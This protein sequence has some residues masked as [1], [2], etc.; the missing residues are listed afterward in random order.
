MT[1]YFKL[2]SEQERSVENYK[3]KLVFRKEELQKYKDILS[4]FDTNK[5]NELSSQEVKSIWYEIRKYAAKDGNEGELSKAEADDLIINHLKNWKVKS[6]DLKSFISTITKTLNGVEKKRAKDD[7]SKE[8]EILGNGVAPKNKY[9]LKNLQKYYPAPEWKITEEDKNFYIIESKEESIYLEILNDG[10]A[11]ISKGKGYIYKSADGKK[12][13]N[14]D[15][16]LRSMP[17][18]LARDVFNNINSVAQKNTSQDLNNLI[19]HVKDIT[20]ENVKEFLKSFKLYCSNEEEDFFSYMNKMPNIPSDKKEILISHVRKCLEKSMGYNDTYMNLN[21]QVKN[22]YYTGV[23]CQ[24]SRKGDYIS[25]VHPDRPWETYSIDLAKLV[26]NLPVE[27]GIRVKKMIQELPGEVLIDL[28]IELRNSSLN[29]GQSDENQY[30]DSSAKKKRGFSAAAW[31]SPNNDSITVGVDGDYDRSGTFV[32]EL[33]HAV[34]FNGG[35]LNTASSESSKVFQ[36]AF[37]K[38]MEVYLSKG[39][40]IY[41]GNEN[42]RYG[43]GSSYATYNEQEMFAECYTLMMTGNCNSKQLILDYFP[44]TL[45]AVGT[46][47]KEV[48]AMD[49]AKRRSK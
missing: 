18:F 43:N 35:I 42:I 48:R 41:D 1:E 19:K 25:V 5:D 32:H 30:L 15:G 39:N 33:G 10:T 17:E 37:K 2:T 34:D 47:L 22:E 24:V 36:N 29:D 21:S 28:A 4:V 7:I 9:T 20:P 45:K 14:A 31:Y 6:E 27:E 49:E 38:E 12:I 44:N 8:L 16:K 26:E 46:L 11:R 13:E 40:K 23:S 3:N